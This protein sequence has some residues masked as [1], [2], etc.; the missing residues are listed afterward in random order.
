MGFMGS[1]IPGGRGR[2]KDS[3]GMDPRTVARSVTRKGNPFTGQ[4]PQV[5]V[6]DMGIPV[7][8]RRSYGSPRPSRRYGSSNL[9][10]PPTPSGPSSRER[11][12]SKIA[13]KVEQREAF[14][15]DLLP[16]GKRSDTRDSALR[17]AEKA[18]LAVYEKSN[19]WPLRRDE[20]VT[21]EQRDADRNV[22]GNAYR[23]ARDAFKAELPKL[24]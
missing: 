4:G 12:A 18:A 11:Q 6:D 21:A 8:A 20:D 10:R 2:R 13:R 3:I 7:P 22:Y 14:N 5:R 17:A 16:T 9:G 1:G 23:A 24:R 15:W 19:H